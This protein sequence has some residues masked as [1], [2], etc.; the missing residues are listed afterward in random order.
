MLASNADNVVDTITG[1]TGASN[2]TRHKPGVELNG[3]GLD[4]CFRRQSG[5]GDYKS[6]TCGSR[7]ILVNHKLLQQNVLGT[8]TRLETGEVV[9][10][11]SLNRVHGEDYYLVV[12]DTDTALP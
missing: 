8:W 12:P 7:Q 11:V 9:G 10:I 3:N 5:Y 6:W 4:S 1:T 2:E